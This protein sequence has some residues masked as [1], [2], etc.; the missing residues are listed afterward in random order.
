VTKA[1]GVL[2]E[3]VR[4]RSPS[5][6]EPALASVRHRSRCRPLSTANCP[7]KEAAVPDTRP[8]EIAVPVIPSAE[9]GLGRHHG[10]PRRARVRPLWLRR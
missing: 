3:H 1:V 8:L 7:T 9:Y 4:G 5:A 2:A 6:A 10:V